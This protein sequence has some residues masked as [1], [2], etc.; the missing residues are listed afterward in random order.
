MFMPSA[1]NSSVTI[2][3]ACSSDKWRRAGPIRAAEA[4][5]ACSRRANHAS[6]LCPAMRVSLT[7]TRRVLAYGDSCV[8]EWNPPRNAGRVPVS[9]PLPSARDRLA[10]TLDQA[11][12][13][14]NALDWQTRR[15]RSKSRGLRRD[16]SARI[17]LTLGGRQSDASSSIC[18]AHIRRAATPQW[19]RVDSRFAKASTSTSTPPRTRS[20]DTGRCTV[21]Y[22]PLHS[23]RMERHAGK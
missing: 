2:L 15:P 10:D 3:A 7:A 23:N 6:P 14:G 21:G 13:V 18:H 11:S 9:R 16:G 8:R 5:M 4:I 22:S 1:E 20:P 17:D 12:S 19:K